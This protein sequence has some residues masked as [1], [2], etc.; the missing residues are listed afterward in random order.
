MY[1]GGEGGERLNSFEF[2]KVTYIGEG[3][4]QL[5]SFEFRKGTYVC[6]IVHYG[7]GAENHCD[8]AMDNVE[9]IKKKKNNKKTEHFFHSLFRSSP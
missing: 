8:C 7:K 5:N 9:I 6:Y 2:R 4:E 1:I 3:G